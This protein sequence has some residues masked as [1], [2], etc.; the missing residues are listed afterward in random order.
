MLIGYL[1]SQQ[2]IEGLI[3]KAKGM[4]EDK[5]K[6]IETA[7]S[8]VLASVDKAKKE[9]KG[10]ADAFLKGLKDGEFSAL[11]Y[12]GRVSRVQRHPRTLTA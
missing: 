4:G 6:E 12:I 11:M 2:D 3:K 10:Q 7:A 5:I 9:G 8:K 1:P